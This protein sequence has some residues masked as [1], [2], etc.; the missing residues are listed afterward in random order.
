MT[1][2]QGTFKGCGDSFSLL[3]T[4]SGP[5]CDFLNGFPG[6]TCQTSGSNLT[7]TN[8]I[9]CNGTAIYTSDFTYTESNVLV[10]QTQN[11]DVGDCGKFIIESDGTPK[12][13]TIK[14]IADPNTRCALDI[15]ML[16][17]GSTNTT[18]FGSFN[19]TNRTT[20]SFSSPSAEPSQ[21][22]TSGSM[23]QRSAPSFVLMGTL[24]ILLF[25][26]FI[27]GSLA[28]TDNT[29]QPTTDLVL[30]EVQAITP[31][32][33]QLRERDLDPFFTGLANVLGTYLGGKLATKVDPSAA[34]DVK[35]FQD[36]F[37]FEFKRALCDWGYSSV[38]FGKI[39]PPIAALVGEC[40]TILASIAWTGG[41]VVEFV[42]VFASGTICN[43]VASY[44]LS[45]SPGMKELSGLLGD[46]CTKMDTLNRCPGVPLS[47]I[48]SVDLL[49]DA[50]NC[51]Y[52][53]NPVS[54][55]L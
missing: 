25:A 11:V 9:S 47:S 2:A 22:Q 29:A 30:R 40:T 45:H 6:T 50:N 43:A 55:I 38:L 51:G 39:F 17:T 37:V 23:P 21:I 46:I 14:T 53:Q 8:G 4:C 35:L 42:A 1:T 36:T 12:G 31:A 27:Q 16:S 26:M 20:G 3:Y 15:G 48:N 49:S 7:C 10:S 5:S 32:V 44:F 24:V 54:Y 19:A 41:P 34:S 52:C 33:S 28:D 13:V 18:N